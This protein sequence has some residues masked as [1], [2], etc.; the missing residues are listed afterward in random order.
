MWNNPIEVLVYTESYNSLENH[1][2]VLSVYIII[3]SLIS[4]S[5]MLFM[6]IINKIAANTLP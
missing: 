2:Q 5:Q 4:G 1:R 6:Y 3:N